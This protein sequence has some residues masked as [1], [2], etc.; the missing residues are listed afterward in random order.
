[1]FTPCWKKKKTLIKKLHHGQ[2]GLTIQG[3]SSLSL[4]YGKHGLRDGVWL[5]KWPHTFMA[6]L[7]FSS[8]LAMAG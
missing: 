2:V 6:T 3:L 4:G 1:M 5:L 7:F 8:S